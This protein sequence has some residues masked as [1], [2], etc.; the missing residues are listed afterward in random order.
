[1]AASERLLR[2]LLDDLIVGHDLR[3]YVLWYYT[4]MALG[5]SRH[6]RPLATVYDCMDELSAFH[7]APALLRERE[8]ELL[9]TADLVFA[10]GR[11]LCSA[12]RELRPSTYLFPSSIDAAHFARARTWSVDPPDQARI[13][14]PRLGYCGVIDERIDLELVAE[15]AA[16]REDFE[17]VMVGPV[18]KIDRARL[19]RRRNIHYLGQKRYAELPA[20]LGGWD[21]AIMPFSHNEATRFISPTKTPEYLAAGRPVVSTSIRD[22]VEPYG[23]LGLVEIADSPAE[24]VAAAS[25]ALERGRHKGWLAQA[26]AFLAGMSWDR[27]WSGMEALISAAVRAN[28]TKMGRREVNPCSTT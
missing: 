18:A 8:R 21:V 24:F 9:R 3:A 17:I 14:R 6:L 2:E 13:G 19:P 4:P 11:S 16:L 7:G 12:K 5:F 23:A 22:V 26:D 28:S 27:T 10:G 25:R 1:R 20:Y 15:V